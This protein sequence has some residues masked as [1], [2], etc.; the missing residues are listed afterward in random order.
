MLAAGV[1]M[2]VCLGKKDFWFDEQYTYF[3]TSLDWS[4]LFASIWRAEMNM[5]LYYAL[6]K[7][8]RYLSD[9]DVHIRMLS[10]LFAVA[11]VPTIYA[12]GRELLE[13]QVGIIAAWLFALHPFVHSRAQ[14]ARGYTL[15]VFLV[16][17]STVCFIRAIR[18]QNIRT[19]MAYGI[20]SGLSVYA[21]FF[22]LFVLASHII[23]LFLADREKLK[24]KFVFTYTVSTTLI[25]IPFIAFVLKGTPD[26]L[27]WVGPMGLFSPVYL[28]FRLSGG[29]TKP[30][31]V[32]YILFV[33]FVFIF[34]YMFLYMANI[35]R[36]ASNKFKKEYLLLYSWVVVPIICVMIIDR[37]VM[38]MFVIRYF[39]VLLPGF[40][41]LMSA[42]IVVLFEDA[43]TRKSIVCLIAGS[44]AIFS[45]ATHCLPYTPQHASTVWTQ[46]ISCIEQNKSKDDAVLFLAPR[47][48]LGFHYYL[49]KNHI[50]DSFH[51]AYSGFKYD[52]PYQHPPNPADIDIVSQKYDTIWFI[53]RTKTVKYE[54]SNA[55]AL[56]VL[57]K[58]YNKMIYFENIDVYLFSRIHE[59]KYRTT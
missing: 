43:W 57:K 42:G 16:T 19:T 38:H 48:L 9:S 25:L 54:Q 36:N 45:V 11:T 2:S 23:Y 53:P 26:M 28:F 22:S 50:R 41:L 32:E 4:G 17:L 20:L 59:I 13:K 44:F 56:K 1:A 14:E 15:A 18:S 30:V 34:I 51:Y 12:L 7:L 21:H 55:T 10:V 39:F 3:C 24:P 47:D 40:L 52:S 27:H 6:V 5:S 33:F 8:W 35:F 31:A 37:I 49:N 46:R 58:K 29:F